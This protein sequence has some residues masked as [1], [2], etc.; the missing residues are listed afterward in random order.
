MANNATLEARLTQI[1]EAF[2]KQIAFE[3]RQA[4]AAQVTSLVAPQ[5]ALEAPRKR[6]R[7]AG[8]TQTARATK[9]PT[10]ARRYPATCLFCEKAHGGPR[11]SFTCPDHASESKASK[12]KA[13]E[14]WKGKQA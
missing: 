5:G 8:G 12:R 4:F 1:T 7:P 9:A 3:V 11:S 6:G 10:Q 13:L 2:V 14:A